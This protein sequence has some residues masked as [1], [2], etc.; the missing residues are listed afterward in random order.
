MKILIFAT[1]FF[2]LFVVVKTTENNIDKNLTYYMA[3]KQ[4]TTGIKELERRILE[5]ISNIDSEHYGKFMTIKEINN[6]LSP[7]LT[8]IEKIRKW[9]DTYD[10]NIVKKYSD[11]LVFRIYEDKFV[12]NDI[13]NCV[14]FIEPLIPASNIRK[15]ISK[16][17]NNENYGVDGVD[18]GFV[19]REVLMRMYNFDGDYVMKNRSS[20]GAM[21]YQ[22][23]NGFSQ[24][25]M[26]TVQLAS[27]VPKN[28]VADNHI[29]GN[30]N[31]NYPDGESLLDM[32]VIWMAA[33]NVDLW[34]EDFDG[35]MYSWA[36][37]FYNR[38]NIPQV[39][40]ISWGWNELYQCIPGLGVC[41]NSRIYV[42]RS[43]VEF[44]KI[45]ARGT[46]IV[47]SSGDAGSP[48]RTNEMCDRERPHINAVFPGGSPWVTSV[49]ATYVEESN[50]LDK[51]NLDKNDNNNLCHVVKC[52]TGTSEA[53][54]SYNKTGWTSGSGFTRWNETPKWQ[55]KHVEKY[56]KNS[57]SLPNSTYFNSE[58]RGYPDVSAF[59]H[60][61]ALF[62]HGWT[63]G[64]GTSCSSPIM[65][66]IIAYLNDFQQR[67]G[68]PRLGFANPLLYRMYEE[69]SDAFNDISKGDSACT[70][71]MCCGQDYGFRPEKG[72][73]D[74]VS[75]LGTPNIGEMI[76]YLEKNI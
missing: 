5:E 47:V 45:V 19:T 36:V 26:V 3:I 49:G 20:V 61:C 14:D 62:D 7:S 59:G 28:E 16:V 60:M 56:L 76:K 69:H 68:K 63:G 34:Y 32:A 37:D 74:V 75:G 31:S 15:H 67:R 70:E 2:I 35:W 41:N 44:M 18:R 17:R 71:T 51:N 6:L 66:G 33:A 23:R 65:A 54:T 11:S 9:I 38:E 39:V 64:D 25:D 57:K 4:N 40:S 13:Q 42:E 21:E 52:A 30:N 1:L 43:N 29:I 53:M 12:M 22:G 72:M 27:G 58:G 24:R 46:T 55:K 73:W 48:G 8:C 50:N 10:V